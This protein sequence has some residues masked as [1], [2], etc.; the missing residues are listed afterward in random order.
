MIKDQ[1]VRAMGGICLSTPQLIRLNWLA[2]ERKVSP[3]QILSEI[4]DE[5][6]GSNVPQFSATDRT[7]LEREIAAIAAKFNKPPHVV[8]DDISANKGHR[9]HLKDSEAKTYRDY[10]RLQ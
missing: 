4:V 7:R 5:Y 6:L 9:Y 2:Q 3:E 1:F 10:L 8:K